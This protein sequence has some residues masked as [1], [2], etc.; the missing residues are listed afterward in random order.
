MRPVSASIVVRGRAVEAEQLWYDPK[1]WASWID[2]FG[3]MTMERAGP[4]RWAV[5]VWSREG[6]IVNRCRIEG[7]QS[8]CEVPQVSAH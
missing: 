7:R 1:R 8:H 6:A 4:R 5:T 2:G 3:Y